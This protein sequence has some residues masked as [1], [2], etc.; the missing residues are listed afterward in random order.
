MDERDKD[1]GQLK[2]KHLSLPEPM[3]VHLYYHTAR[4]DSSGRAWFFTDP[5]EHDEK[6]LKVLWARHPRYR[7]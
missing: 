7:G 5:Y 1:T 2:Q 4:A 6:R 3:P